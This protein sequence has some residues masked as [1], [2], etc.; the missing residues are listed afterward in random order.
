VTAPTTGERLTLNAVPT[1][2]PMHNQIL[3]YDWGSTSALAQLQSRTPSG[4][5]EAELWMGAHPSAPSELE[6]A[7]GKLL[8]LAEAVTGYPEPV[9]GPAVLSVF[10]DRLPFVLK[11][12]A[13]A[14]PLS[15][16]VH[17]DA[18]RAKAVYRPDGDSPYVDPF[19][20]PELLYALEPVEALFGFRTPALAAMLIGRLGSERLAELVSILQGDAGATASSERRI[21]LRVDQDDA[22][23]L[24]AALATLIT[25]PLED[26]AA[27]VAE[28]AAACARL[29]AGGSTDYPEAFGWLDRLV[30]LH[31]ADP[32]V[33][34][35]LLLDIVRLSPGQTVFVPAG[36]PHCYLSGLGIEILAASDNVLRCGLTSKPVEVEELLQVIDCRPL[37]QS[38]TPTTTLGDHE[39]AWRP[40]VEDFQLSRIAVDGDPVAADASVAGPQI[41]FCA[42]GRVR[43][44]AGEHSV[45]LT[46]GY[47]AFV[48]AEAGPITVSG[49]GQVFRA[50]SGL[51]P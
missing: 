22:E 18:A 40:E 11:V 5:P 14:R 42:S 23:R 32:M 26:R 6:L 48:T 20:K 16:Q 36:V 2:A 47:S 19:H 33:L 9:L 50:A 29:R 49:E 43:I 13:I 34:A 31:P 39:T 15:V 44:Q 10:G 8:P 27:L 37:A 3:G 30:G 41:V 28:I 12:L 38:T 25:W 35:P 24:H 51:L 4:G 46:A 1:I 45:D 17:P 21:E 7:D